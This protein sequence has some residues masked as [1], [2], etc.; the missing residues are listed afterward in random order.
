MKKIGSVFTIISIVL[1][2]LSCANSTPSVPRAD[3][4]VMLNQAVAVSKAV[5]SSSNETLSGVSTYSVSLGAI[6][7]ENGKWIISAD[8][9]GKRNESF[10]GTA[11]EFV[12]K[13]V[14]LGTYAV[15]IDAFGPDGKTKMFNG[16]GDDYLTVSENDSNSV[17]VSLASV[18]TGKYTGSASI[19]F[20]WKDIAETNE[21]IKSAMKDGGL[22]FILYYYDEASSSWIEAGRSEPTGTSTTWYQFEVGNLPV[23]TGIQ[24]KYALATKSG[25]MLNPA[26]YSPTTQIFSDLTAKQKG[27]DNSDIY[28]IKDEEINSS[29]NVYDVSYSSDPDEGSSVTLTWKNQT[30]NGDVLFDYVTIKYS[31][32][33]VS[34]KTVTVQTNGSDTSSYTITD[35]AMG[36][37]YT[38]SFQAH[39]KTGL[40]SSFYTFPEKV[41]AKIILEAPKSISI[42]TDG[43][44]FKITWGPVDGADSYAI[45]RSVNGRDFTFLEKVGVDTKLYS[46]SSLYSYNSYA[47]K[48]MGMRGEVEGELS[49]PTASLKI[50]ENRVTVK[51]PDLKNDFSITPSDKDKMAI[52]PGAD[53]FC[54]SISDKD[55]VLE[56]SWRINGNEV[57]TASAEKGG[58][59]LNITEKNA[60]EFGLVE[61]SNKLSLNIKTTSGTYSSTPEE[62]VYVKVPS[63]GVKFA[64][65]QNRFSTTYESGET[66]TIQ[67]SAS[68]LPANSTVKDVVYK[69]SD[70]SI[71]KVDEETGLVTLTG[72]PG[73]V[74]I[75]ASPRFFPDIQEELELEIYKTTITSAEQLVNKV[76]EIIHTPIDKANTAFSGDWWAYTGGEIGENEARVY[77]STGVEI[78]NSSSAFWGT[79]QNSGSI[80]FINYD[81]EDFTLNGSLSTYAYNPGGIGESGY[82]GTDPLNYIGYGDLNNTLTVTLPYNQGTATV[83]YNSVN[84]INRG[85]SYT[86]TFNDAIGYDGTLVGKQPDVTDSSSI[87]PI[88]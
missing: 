85:G 48:V 34:E 52:L 39:H 43:N 12:I 79:T 68:T 80:K 32:P 61:G 17:S 46:D 45:Y 35:M 36:D 30:E 2:I 44:A 10:P 29:D 54:V 14:E 25:V 59:F 28:T 69:S 31:S 50:S 27:T 76:N 70:V 82:L 55:E 77:T 72:E 20:N 57:K 8:Q 63:T 65:M 88:L 78:K 3:A 67:L 87:T 7:K 24:L 5:G 40:V 13:N 18:N 66:R 75:S 56:Y 60:I 74:V 73:N 11:S 51:E 41:I 38:V 47:Y 53:G 86:V 42:D 21:T 58:T 22:V 16:S 64:S 83:K 19:T 62:F 1:M 71:A 15:I 9:S 49:L 23:S 81:I 26:L 6:S 84:V 4:K 37:E 33:L